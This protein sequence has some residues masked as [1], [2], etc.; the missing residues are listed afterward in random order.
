MQTDDIKE[1]CERLASKYQ[2]RQEFDDLVSVGVLKCLELVAEGVTSPP[3]LYYRARDEMNDYFNR[4]SS[5]ISYSKGG[6]GR[7]QHKAENNSYI[8]ALDAEIQ[9]IDT[10]GSFEVKNVLEALRGELTDYEKK[11]MLLLY[12]NDNNLQAVGDVIGVTARAV[13]YT[14]DNIRNKLVTICDL[15]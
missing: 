10:Y 11:V 15:P 2:N 12:N 9:A 5:P 14:R 8:D 6:Q 4:K 1:M 13:G 3:A 7:E